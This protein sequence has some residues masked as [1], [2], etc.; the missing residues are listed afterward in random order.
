MVF[1]AINFAELTVGI[2]HQ[3][4]FHLLNFWP[5]ESLLTVPLTVILYYSTKEGKCLP[6]K[7]TFHSLRNL[8]RL[9]GKDKKGVKLVLGRDSIIQEAAFWTEC[10]I[11]WHISPPCLQLLWICCFSCSL[12][13]RGLV[14]V[15]QEWKDRQDEGMKG[16][17][18]FCFCS[19]FLF[20]C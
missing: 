14:R 17:A 16:W 7:N 2:K 11:L 4:F 5:P 19:H 12:F 3:P 8:Q 18:T 15:T 1:A 6:L 9:S 20:R 10:H 13:A